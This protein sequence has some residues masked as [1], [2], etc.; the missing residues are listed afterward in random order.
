[1]VKS[2]FNEGVGMGSLNETNIVLVPK[3]DKPEVVGQFRPISL[4]NY[5]YKVVSKVIVNR[6]KA[7]KFF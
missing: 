2:F 4:C 3:V 1:M 5:A 7:Y 6:M